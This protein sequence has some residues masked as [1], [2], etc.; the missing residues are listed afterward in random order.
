MTKKQWLWFWLLALLFL[1][2]VCIFGKIDNMKLNSGSQVI[3]PAPVVKAVKVNKLIEPAP[4]VEVAKKDLQFKIVKS[5]NSVTMSGIL[6]Q[7]SDFDALSGSY[8]GLTNDGL[9]FDDG[10]E[11]SSIMKLVVGLK[12]IFSKFK[13]GFIEYSDKGLIVNGIVSSVND[14]ELADL[15]LDS[16][17]DLNIES[18][19]VVELP[20]PK[21]EHISKLS[22]VKSDDSIIV[23]GIFSSEAEIDSLVTTLQRDGVS[24]SKRLCIVDSDLQE[25]RW[26]ILVSA[27]VD[28]FVNNFSKGTIQFDKDRFDISGE[29]IVEGVKEKVEQAIS[30]NIADIKLEQDITYVKPKPTKEQ[31]QSEINSILKLKNI[32]FVRATAQLT[33]KGKDTLNE[34]LKIFK[35]FPNL[36]ILISGHTDSD[37]S[38]MFNLTLSQDRADAVK[39]YLVENGLH[40]EN[41]TSRGFG[42]G[43][44]LVKNSSVANK[45]INRRV[46]FTIQ[47]K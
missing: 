1:I 37:G 16:V 14:K 4:V 35:K 33:S 34:V 29:T 46:E 15:A 7:K 31:I 36:K 18:N 44:P 26:K 23:S 45:Q 40:K 10:Y 3:E 2:L 9:S 22:I 41:L 13:S 17:T 32:Q 38:K 21:V 24:V 11:N 27:V 19:I 42:E 6:N 43:S 28:D 12:D 39:N 5:E 8:A 25:N 30:E 47:G 20:K